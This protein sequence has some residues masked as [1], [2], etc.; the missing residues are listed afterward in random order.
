MN[1]PTI[2]V[3]LFAFFRTLHVEA[4][5]EITANCAQW[6]NVRTDTAIHNFKALTAALQSSRRQKSI[7]L[8]EERSAVLDH[9]AEVANQTTP[10]E[11][12]FSYE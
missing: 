8:P 9:I 4:A 12:G 11:E 5:R 10:E 7:Y 1:Q 6:G 2:T 3:D